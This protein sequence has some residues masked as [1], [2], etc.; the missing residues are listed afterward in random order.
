MRNPYRAARRAARGDDP[1]PNRLPIGVLL[2]FFVIVF[3]LS[4]IAGV[5]GGGGDACTMSCP[6]W[7]QDI[8]GTCWCTP[9]GGARG[10]PESH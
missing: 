5:S 10:A 4:Q 8:D 9:P 3:S 2:F 1:A 6:V 7:G